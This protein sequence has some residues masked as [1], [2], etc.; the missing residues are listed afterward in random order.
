[1]K[2][3]MLVSAVRFEG[4][5]TFSYELKSIEEKYGVAFLFRVNQA[6][7]PAWKAGEQIIIELPETSETLPPLSQR[8]KEVAG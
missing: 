8:L 5:S 4:H 1:M 2:I 7:K 3:R 6:Y